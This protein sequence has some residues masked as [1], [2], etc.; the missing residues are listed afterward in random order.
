[1]KS[2][3]VDSEQPVVAAGQ[4]AKQGETAKTRV[5]DREEFGDERLVDCCRT[6]AAGLDAK[7]VAERVM[8]TVAAWSVGTEQ[9]DDTTVVVIDVAP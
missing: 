6:I 2:R 5:F 3:A 9:F 4:P 7:G 1:M 8:Q